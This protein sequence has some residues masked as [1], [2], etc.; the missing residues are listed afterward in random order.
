[1]TTRACRS[2]L[3]FAELADYW[4]DD[5]DA[6]GSRRVEDHLF[7][8]ASCAERTARAAELVRALRDVVPAV[9]SGERLRALADRG[10]R[11]R[12]TEV[13]PDTQVTVAFAPGVDLLIHR[14][15]GDLSHAF[16]VDCDVLDGRGTPLLSLEHVPVDRA[17]GE[18]LIA[19]QRH[20]LAEY[21][22]DIRFRLSVVDT[23]GAIATREYRV[24]HE[25]E[26]G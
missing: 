22:P 26:R 9:L 4:T 6:D 23:N 5:L 13:P 2:P 21:P 12:E 18:V 17:A 24:F 3:S 10:V 14:L 19:C 25:A 8:C 20:Y 7:A 15:K 16:W 1:M 11:V